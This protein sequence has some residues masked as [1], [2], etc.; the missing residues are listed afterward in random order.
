MFGVYAQQHQAPPTGLSSPRNI[1]R[2]FPPRMEE[3]RKEMMEEGRKEMMEGILS[4]TMEFI[5]LMTG[6]EYTMV[7]KTSGDHVT[8]SSY[9]RA[10]EDWRTAMDPPPPF[11]IPER[12]NDKKILEIINKI[13]E[14]LTGEVPIRCQDVA[15]YFSMEEWEYMERN[16]DTL[17]EDQLPLTPPDER[18]NNNIIEIAFP[19]IEDDDIS[20]DSSGKHS[21]SSD[22]HPELHCEDL[23]SPPSTHERFYPAILPATNREVST[24]GEAL[25][26]SEHSECLMERTEFVL[27]QDSKTGE[28]LYS[29]LERGKCFPY[30][31]HLIRHESAH[32]VK[33]PYSCWECGKCF[34]YRSALLLHE[35]IHTGEKPFSCSQCQKRFNRKSTLNRHQIMHTGDK[36]YCC[37]VCGK[38]FSQR[39]HLLKH[40]RVHSGERPFPCVECGKRFF[41]QSDL[42]RHERAHR[43]VKPYSCSQCGKG[44]SQKSILTRHERIHIG[45]KPD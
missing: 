8:F 20:S 29:C 1:P 3:G 24:G 4:L 21:V 23:S 13:T 11:L 5:Y 9:S 31:S 41:Q 7:K 35:M 26:W 15:V 16:K 22:L 19:D 45:E 34:L 37:S 33:G 39:P 10:S 43:G 27:F 18:P 36:S 44:F 38:C 12:N 28:N 40:D 32:A 42:N 14:L 30:K 2:I 17:M 25:P 6:E